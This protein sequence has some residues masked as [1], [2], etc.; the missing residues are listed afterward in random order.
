MH[1]INLHHLLAVS[2]NAERRPGQGQLQRPAAPRRDGD[3]SHEHGPR[4][5]ARLEQGPGRDG[6]GRRRPPQRADRLE[7]SPGDEGARPDLLL[8]EERGEQRR[9]GRHRGGRRRPPPRVTGSLQALGPGLDAAVDALHQ[10]RSLE[11]RTEW[12]VGP[13]EV[14]TPY[15][16]KSA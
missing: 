4:D 13:M 1:Y 14:A 7:Q 12:E 11:R 3:G 9:P 6:G 10:A 2:G 16:I 15:S 5:H 8:D